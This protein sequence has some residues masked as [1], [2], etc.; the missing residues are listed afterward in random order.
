MRCFDLC[1]DGPV[2]AIDTSSAICAVAASVHG[3]AFEDTRLLGR[4]HNEQALGMVAALTD[5]V[6]EAF[7][8]TF[9][10][11][12]TVAFGC[13]PGS[14]TGVRIAASMAQAMAFAHSAR[15]VR[16][17]SM[18]LLA[19]SL[20]AAQTVPP[21]TQLVAAVRSR[22]RAYYV[23]RLRIDAAA[24]VE[25]AGTVVLLEQREAFDAWCGAEVKEVE[26]VVPIGELPPWL[27]TSSLAARF[28]PCTVS[29]A[30][31]L[32]HLGDAH[33]PLESVDAAL[34]EYIEADSPWS[35]SRSAR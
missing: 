6:R 3:K 14:F 23:Q 32:R 8:D 7:P 13:G 26:A 10:R 20:L 15:I 12:A 11:F 28:V 29:A 21:G 27:E 33:L 1:S 24:Q 35:E 2:L 31:L 4:L 16:L 19:H 34:P 30:G 5:A 25:P 18:P 22:Q 17:P 9:E